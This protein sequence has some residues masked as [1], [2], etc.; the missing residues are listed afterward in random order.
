V[1]HGLSQVTE[2]CDEAVWLERGHV[3]GHGPSRSVVRAYLDSVNERE[4][5][6]ATR[7][8]A[9]PEPAPA[10][11]P[12]ASVAP[13][14]AEPAGLAEAQEISVVAAPA[15]APV[16]MPRA[17]P[18][19]APA[20]GLPYRPV[21][22]RR[23]TGEIRVKELQFLNESGEPTSLLISG[24]PC[25]FRIQY[26]A[27]EAVTGAVFGLGF[28]NHAD[29]TVGGINN[30]HLPAATFGPGPGQVTF[31]ATPLLLAGGNYRV[32]T[33]VHVANHV[34]DALDEGFTLRV[35]APD[36]EI[37]GAYLQPGEWEISQ[38]S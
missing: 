1:S 20:T 36:V 8:E 19:P 33:Q 35:R 10:P 27:S 31:T 6:R 5:A 25:K 28:D 18:Q 22:A 26:D 11:P 12:Q 30:A 34:I 4:A 16:S 9:A 13:E 2:L 3:M 37:D 7:A 23:G 24:K 14:A 38:I 17:V 21:Q 29:F 32:R 15:A